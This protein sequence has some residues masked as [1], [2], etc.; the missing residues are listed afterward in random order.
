VQHLGFAGTLDADYVDYVIAD[1]V[2]IPEH[3]Q[4][5]YA[6][7]VVY[8]PDSYMPTDSRRAIAERT[9]SHAEAGLPDRGFV[10]CAFNNTYKFSP[11]VFDVW[12]RLLGAVE[13]SVLWLPAANASACR[14][15]VREAD[16]RGVAGSRLVFAPYVASGADH[17]ARLS[18]ADLFLDT[19]FYNAHSS[20]SDALWAGFP[21][22]TQPG[23]TFAGRVGASLLD[24]CGLDELIA[25][26]AA[27]YE[28]IALNL[29]RDESA[30]A[31]LK[32][33]LQRNRHSWPLFDTAGFARHLEAAY[34]TMWE[35]HQRGR[36]PHSFSV[37]RMQA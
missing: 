36:E 12:M 25:D 21:V 19:R 16:A 9:P 3:N 13:G 35:S 6:E 4:R 22:L 30:H 28:A 37:P 32:A 24:A 23:D 10:F 7:K 15:L 33:K 14:N 11:E 17:L 31:E 27:S 18:L 20:A 29:A 2:V 34:A 1:K 5:H 8:L 26:S